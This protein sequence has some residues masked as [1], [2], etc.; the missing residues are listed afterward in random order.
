MK[1][2]TIRK[3]IY[4]LAVFM[5][6]VPLFA[7]VYANYFIVLD[8]AE[9][10]GYYDLLSKYEKPGSDLVLDL[11][12]RENDSLQ[13]AANRLKSVMGLGMCSVS[14]SYNDIEKPPAYITDD[15]KYSLKISL[16][17][18][19]KGKKEQIGVL[20]HELSH[21]YVTRLDNPAF[22][23]CD[24]ERLVDCAGVFLGLSA[25]T[26]NG[27]TDDFLFTPGGYET[28]RKFFGYIKPEQFGYLFARYAVENGVPPGRIISYLKWAGRKYFMIGLNYLKR[29]GGALAL[30]GRTVGAAY[31]CRQ[32]GSLI[33]SSFDDRIKG[34]KC[35][36]CGA[37][38]NIM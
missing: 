22:A 37:R 35:P 1:K 11:G 10:D 33:R 13:L 15:G 19:L 25:L 3:M 31:W 4:F 23:K 9:V 20:V 14:L 34:A 6:A 2:K 17:N 36:K 21:A 18:R 29:K 24:Q 38:F 16:S 26:L 12:V 30:S 32:C 8:T 28:E 7:W 27:L 5:V